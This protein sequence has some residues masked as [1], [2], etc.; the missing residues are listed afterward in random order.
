MLIYATR[1]NTIE[2]ILTKMLTICSPF[3]PMVSELLKSKGIFG[4]S[5]WTKINVQNRIPK[6]ALK[7]LFVKMSLDH[8]ALKI[9]LL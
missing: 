5:F 6:G 8:N 2:T 3:S 1:L 9:F 7:N 4:F